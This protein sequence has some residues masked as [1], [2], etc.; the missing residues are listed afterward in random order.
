MNLLDLLPSELD[1]AAQMGKIYGVVIGI[2]TNNKDEE[3]LGRVKVRFPWLVED[4]ESHWARVATLMAGPCRGSFFLPEVDDEVLVAFDHGDVRFP[5]V[6][7]AL[8]N[9]KDRPPYEN[10]DGANNVRAIKS[11]SNH[12]IILNDTSGSAKIQIIDATE[13]N[14][15]TIDASANTMTLQ[16]EGDIVLKAAKGKIILDAQSVEIASSQTT[17]VQA[18]SSMEVTARQTMTVKGQTVHIN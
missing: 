12:Q 13:K 9:G 1:T 2:V 8:W 7:G 18:G 16:V 4:D 5:Y 11:R 3:N 17:Q 15:L 6:I 14:S 10:A